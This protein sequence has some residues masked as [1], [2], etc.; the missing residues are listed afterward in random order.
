MP[1][2]PRLRAVRDGLVDALR[3]IE[4]ASKRVPLA[5]NPAT[6]HLFIIKPF[7][8][9]GV[10][11]LFSTHPP[12]EDRI[13]ALL[14]HRQV[15]RPVVAV[16]IP[17]GL[18]AAA[19]RSSAA[20]VTRLAAIVDGPAP[21]GAPF[22]ALPETGEGAVH[23][24]EFDIAPSKIGE[25]AQRVFDRALDEARRR[26]QPLLTNEH[27]FLGFAQVEW[28]LYAQVMR[29][30]DLDPRAMVVEV[31]RQLQAAPARTRHEPQV[32]PAT[33]LLFKLAFHHASRAGR[34]RST[35][36]ICSRRSSRTPRGC[37]RRSCGGSRRSAIGSWRGSPRACATSSCA[38]SG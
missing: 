25:S 38:T 26:E 14:R 4:S 2:A 32:S 5:A 18:T 3:K 6:A 21:S 7:P 11:A 8:A 29:D 35:R 36:P 15:T 19:F 13:A 24:D 27:V 33:K 30:L 23:V 34:R 12:T 17:R 20:T 10:F 1:R 22:R 16:L 28:E 9:G 37:R 31:E